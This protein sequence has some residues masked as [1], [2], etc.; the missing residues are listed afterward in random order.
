MR[1][2]LTSLGL[3]LTTR[4]RPL[5]SANYRETTESIRAALMETLN[6]AAT[7]DA[8]AL[9]QRIRYE[10]DAQ[11]LWYLRPEVMSVLASLHGE[12]HAREALARISSLFQGV[13]P[14]GLACKLHCAASDRGLAPTQPLE[15]LKESA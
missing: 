1:W 2:F 12:A 3:A 8:L 10:S 14:N 9:L 13:L 5:A 7:P 11:R 6:G 15:I 4:R